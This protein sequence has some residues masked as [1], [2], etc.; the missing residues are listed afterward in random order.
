M[1]AIYL[2]LMQTPI[3]GGLFCLAALGVVARVRMAAAAAPE[4]GRGRVVLAQ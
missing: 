4:P 1:C 2:G 3:I